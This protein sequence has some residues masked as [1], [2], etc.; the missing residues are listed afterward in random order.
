MPSLYFVNEKTKK[1]YKVLK[2]NKQD[3]TITMQGTRATFTE[4]YDKAK[5]AKMGYVLTQ[6]E[7]EAAAA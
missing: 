5:F 4:P 2:M 7:D 6:V 1:R 3:N